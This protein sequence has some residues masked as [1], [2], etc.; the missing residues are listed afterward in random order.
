[1]PPRWRDLGRPLPYCGHIDERKQK[2]GQR[3]SQTGFGSDQTGRVTYSYNSLGYRGAEYRPD[4]PLRVFAFGESNAFGLGVEQDRCWPAL[5]ASRVAAAIGLGAGDVNLVNFAQPGASNAEIARAVVTQVGAVRPDLA[6]I[7][8]APV[9][10]TEGAVNGQVYQVGP[11]ALQEATRRPIEE[12]PECEV[13]GRYLQAL[14]R[15]ECYLSFTD[16]VQGTLD[17]LRH[18]LL[19]QSYLAARGVPAGGTCPRWV[20]EVPDDRGR[21]HPAIGP[22]L[23]QV[24]PAFL[25]AT[26]EQPDDRSA[27]GFHYGSRRHAAVADELFGR[28]VAQGHVD[29]LQA[30][31][32]ARRAAAARVEPRGGCGVGHA[33]R[34][35]Y[36]AMP[37][38]L[39]ETS[40]SSADSIRT[41]DLAKAYPDLHGL[42]A[43]GAVKEVFEIGC[44]AGW[45]ANTLAHHYGVRVTAVDFT[46]AALQRARQVAAE[47]GTT[48]S[49]RFVESD[50]HA[51]EWD[52]DPEL[53]VSLGVL[54]HT[55][56]AAGAFAHMVSPLRAGGHAYLGLYHEPGRRVFLQR[57]REILEREGEAAALEEFR[58]LDGVRGADETLLRSW[59]RDQ[60]IHPH[61]T[62]HTLREVCAWLDAAGMELSSTSIDAF[63]GSADREA[64]FA[65]EQGYAARSHRAN[66]VEGRFFPGFFTVLAR[67]PRA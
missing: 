25:G 27:E 48:D 39:R 65:L 4:A 63:G 18:V 3:W 33:V 47:L 40:S 21:G 60:V 9:N 61:E 2:L 51:Y 52:R 45:L 53:V 49:V 24:C 30:L 22:L 19:V 64:L 55:A 14:Q 59:F 23:E 66:C 1:M 31:V 46:S 36:E 42:L 62:Q 5:V 20:L 29:R 7:G 38:N 11:W 16:V 50:L 41:H 13:K 15:A 58:R 28:L 6:L 54:H 8:V 35:F 56:D 57:M 34:S 17:M 32:R 67:R 10:R 37:F 44:G 12:M 43:T 26:P